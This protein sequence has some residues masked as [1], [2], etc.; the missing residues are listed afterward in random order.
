MLLKAARAIGVVIYLVLVLL[1]L[2]WLTATAFDYDVA[3]FAAPVIAAVA[4]GA[5]VWLGPRE[6]MWGWFL[7]V[8][9]VG[10]RY[11]DAQLVQEQLAFLAFAMIGFL[12]LL[13]TPWLIAAAWLVHIGWNFMPRELSTYLADLPTFSL[14]IDVIISAWLG[15][16]I[17]SAFRPL[18]PLISF[19]PAE[20]P[21]RP[22]PPGD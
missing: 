12:G 4:I 3:V 17:W 9:W 7:L 8:V 1:V 15:W 14:I 22:A 21:D 5:L 19:I 16:R 10:A 11:G 13:F 20:D 18:R 2:Q 6:E